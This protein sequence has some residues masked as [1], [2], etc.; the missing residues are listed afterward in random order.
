MPLPLFKGRNS[1]FEDNV[2]EEDEYEM[3]YLHNII[4][5]AA[6]EQDSIG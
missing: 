1:T 5:A 6:I 3:D 4:R 2:E